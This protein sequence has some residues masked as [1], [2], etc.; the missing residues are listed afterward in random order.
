[1]AGRW[2][3]EGKGAPTLV[4]WCLLAVCIVPYSLDAATCEEFSPFPLHQPILIDVEVVDP[5]EGATVPI[6]HDDQ[7]QNFSPL[8][9]HWEVQGPVGNFARLSPA[10]NRI[11]VPLTARPPPVS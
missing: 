8:S 6:S 7:T 5:F 4:G 2:S 11:V 3:F 10:R 1:M 9:G